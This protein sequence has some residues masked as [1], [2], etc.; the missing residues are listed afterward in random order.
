MWRD[1]Q[2]LERRKR[3]DANTCANG[4][5]ETLQT[6]QWKILAGLEE[7]KDEQKLNFAPE[8]AVNWLSFGKRELLTGVVALV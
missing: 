8:A 1:V 4:L 2:W 5:A 7:N 6:A 3:Q